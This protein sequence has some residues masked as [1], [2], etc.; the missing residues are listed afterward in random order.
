MQV[1]GVKGDIVSTLY[2]QHD[3]TRHPEEENV[4]GCFH[5]RGGVEVAQVFGVIGPTESGKRP[6]P[7][8]EP[9]V[10]D[11]FVPVN[12]CAPAVLTIGR[13]GNSRHLLATVITIPDGDAM[14]P[15]Q[16]PGD[17]PVSDVLHPVVVDLGEALGDN[18]DAPVAHGLD[19]PLGQGLDLDEP[20][21]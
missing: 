8:G 17:A 2:P 13:I 10:E 6:Q 14:T 15:P 7:R 1:D 3:H 21:G 9:G 5:D 11:V 19:G 16:L 20:L 18:A 4:V 12:T